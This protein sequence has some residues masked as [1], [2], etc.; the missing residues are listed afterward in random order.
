MEQLRITLAATIRRALDRIDMHHRQLGLL[1][2]LVAYLLVFF[3]PRHEGLRSMLDYLADALVSVPAYVTTVT[4]YFATAPGG[5]MWHSLWIGAL[6]GAGATAVVHLWPRRSWRRLRALPVGVTLLLV[7]GGA[8]AGALGSQ[9]LMYP[10]RHC[11]YG[12]DI[13]AAQFRLGV[14]ITLFSALFGLVPYWA[15]TRRGAWRRYRDT[16]G[17][18]SGIWWPYLFLAPTVIILV[19]FLYYPTSQIM[20]QSLTKRV[21][22]IRNKEQFACLA[23]YTSL[24]DDQL[25]RDSFNATLFITIFIVLFSL[26]IALGIA[27]LASQKVKG[28]SIYR[29]LLIWP[30]AISPVVTGVIFLSMFREGGIGLINYGLDRFLAT[31]PAWLDSALEATVGLDPDNLPRWLSDENLAPWVVI[32]ASVWN[33]LGFNIL[34][35]IAGLQNVPQDLLEAASLDGANR[36]QRFWRVTFP[37][38]SPFTFFLLITNITY[39]FYG[40]YGVIETLT[41]GQHNTDVLIYKMYED[42]FQQGS[43]YVGSAGA[44][45]VILFLMVA[46]LTLLQFRYIER[47]ITYGG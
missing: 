7:L 41:Q 13:A 45:A 23:N 9:I 31:S 47:R 28:A 43:P 29:T 21:Q 15:L 10:T 27:V 18:F 46:G 6:F 26:M 33:L 8:V 12:P 11:S 14:G 3:I 39:S 1:A 40:I 30:Y 16:S 37:L 19:L 38:L 17:Y 42:A 34:F 20:S 2:L 35:Y 36:F 24:V 32:A 25:Y 4:D 22:F 44:Q 5:Q